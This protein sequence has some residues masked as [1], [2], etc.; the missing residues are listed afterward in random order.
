MY[1]ILA[2]NNFISDTIFSE[3]CAESNF[4]T[5]IK[6]FDNIAEDLFENFHELNCSNIKLKF[7]LLNKIAEDIFVKLNENNSLDRNFILY[8]AEL[9][10]L[11]KLELKQYKDFFLKLSNKKKKISEN[12]LHEKKFFFNQI[13]V[14]T[15]NKILNITNKYKKIFEV[16][17]SK[18]LY[19]RNDLSINTGKDI[20]KIIKILNNEFDQ[21]GVNNIVSNYI[22][23]KFKVIGCA[24][25]LSTPNSTWWKESENKKISSQ[26]IYAHIDQS[27]TC[28]KSICY[29]SDVEIENGPTSFYPGVYEN[30][31]LNFFQ[32]IFGRIN[33]N[34]GQNKNSKLYKIYNKDLNRLNDSPE[35]LKH[36]SKIPKNIFFDSHLGWYIKKDSELEKMFLQKEKFML[37]KKGLFVVFD[38][39]KLFHRGG[40]IKKDTRLVLQITFGEQV[41]I[42]QKIIKKIYNIIS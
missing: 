22:R 10:Q 35:R 34:V 8:I 3:I 12:V 19:S 32:N 28:P 14:N 39:S 6:E 31:K 20:R 26:T 15:L 30:L 18:K 5:E 25:E 4:E 23:K 40:C 37:G 11:Y 41:N 24:I 36:L 1:Q 2:K 42:I 21:N 17:I 13:K 9:K 16:N 7:I 33:L 29:L 27:L 38:G